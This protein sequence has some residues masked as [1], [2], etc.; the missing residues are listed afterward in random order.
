M[1]SD[2]MNV[3]VVK[4]LESVKAEL[5]ALKEHTF[6]TQLM[7]NIKHSKQGAFSYGKEVTLWLN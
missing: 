7:W 5:Q 6:N 4:E 1:P 2:D 3:N